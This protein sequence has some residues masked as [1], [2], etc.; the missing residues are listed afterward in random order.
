MN[1]SSKLTE[2]QLQLIIDNSEQI[3]NLTDRVKVLED[4]NEILRSQLAAMGLSPESNTI[5][6]DAEDFNVENVATL[7]FQLKLIL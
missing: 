5:D 3:G 6:E 4:E 1:V 7:L 2:E